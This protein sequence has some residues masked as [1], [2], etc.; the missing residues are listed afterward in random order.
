M[1]EFVNSPMIPFVLPNVLLIAEMSTQKEYCDY[2]LNHLK[3]I[4][5]LT[6]PIQILLIFMQKMDLL[7]KLTPAEE[8]KLHVLP[9][10]YRS[11]ECEMTQLQEL[12][13]NVLPTFSTLIDYNA[14]KNSVIPRIKKLCLLST[15]V[16][17]KVNCLISIGKLLENLDKWLVLDEILPFL[18]HINSRE[19]AIIM[20]IIGNNIFLKLTKMI[21]NI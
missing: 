20:A 5:K 14:M 2:I 7:L 21:T 12:C 1:K 17:I 3:P 18:Q 11:L 8:V 13:L 16:G 6:E 4:F 10:L 9:L 15:N 19:P